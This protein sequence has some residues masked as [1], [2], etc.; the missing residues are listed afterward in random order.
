[1]SHELRTPLTSIKGFAEILLDS[2]NLD[3]EKKTR[4]L[5]I[6][7]VEANRMSRLISD[8]LDLTKIESGTASWVMDNSDLGEIVRRSAAVLAPNAAEKGIELAVAASEFYPVCADADRVQEVITNLVGNA[9]KF[10]SH[11]GRIG[12]RL[13]RVTNSGPHSDFPGDFV[14]VAVADN[15]PGI[16]PDERERVFDKFYQGR[17]NRSAGS[18]AG[19]GL[20][21]SR[22]IVLHHKGEIW[23]D[24]ELG[25]GSTFY[26]TVPLQPP[27]GAAQ[28]RA[29]ESAGREA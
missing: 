16:P 17:R 20:A 19:L 15:G 5:G 6:I 25:V 1:V 26:F 23:V 3:A 13:D 14:R 29:S 12:L 21:I 22:E 8:F 7:E 24:S 27:P 10:C 4:F 9:V 28:T 18:G 11:G 2:P